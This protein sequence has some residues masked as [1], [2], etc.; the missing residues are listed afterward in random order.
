MWPLSIV[1]LF[2]TA[3]SQQN[4]AGGDYV[5]KIPSWQGALRARAALVQPQLTLAPGDFDQNACFFIRSYHFERQNGSAPV[6]T[7][8]TT[9]TPSRILEQKRVS[10]S[11]GLYVPLALQK[12]DLQSDDLQRD[13]QTQPR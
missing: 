7:G 5:G 11:R 4:S 2:A 6:L 12:D 8:M 13:D 10:P 9:C 1:L 3:A